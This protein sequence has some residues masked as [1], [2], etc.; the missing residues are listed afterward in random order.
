MGSTRSQRARMHFCWLPPER[1]VTGA[2][3]PA[4]LIASSLIDPATA[5]RSACDRSGPN[6]QLGEAADRDVLGHGHLVEEAQ[7]LRSSVTMAMPASIASSGVRNRD[8]LP[9]SRIVPDGGCGL[10]P[11]IASSSSVRPAPRRPATP[12]TSPARTER[13]MPRERAGRSPA[14]GAATGSRPRRPSGS[15]IGWRLDSQ[16]GDLAAD[17]PAH[18]LRRR[19]RLPRRAGDELAVAEHGHPVGQREDLVHLVA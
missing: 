19:R 3:P 9:S 12:R 10:A 6:G 15:P 7:G 11:K 13:L 1:L 4:V 16:R 8:G 2:S 5:G 18:D 14:G 17:H